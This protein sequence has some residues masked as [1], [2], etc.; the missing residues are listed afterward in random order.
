VDFR[1]VVLPKKKNGYLF[2]LMPELYL[3]LVMP[4]EQDSIIPES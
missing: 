3:F 2:E 4:L 1:K